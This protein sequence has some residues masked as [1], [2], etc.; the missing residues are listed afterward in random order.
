MRDS[1][2]DQF[3]L[4]YLGYI[5]DPVHDWLL[6]LACL[7]AYVAIQSDHVKWYHAHHGQPQHQHVPRLPSLQRYRAM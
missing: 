3:S 4:H 6:S 7:E 2:I 5:D 1:C